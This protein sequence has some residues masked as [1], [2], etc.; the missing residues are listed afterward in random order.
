[1]K[2]H[3]ANVNVTVT[4]TIT[5]TNGTTNVGIEIPKQP[6]YEDGLIE[7]AQQADGEWEAA[8]EQV[9]PDDVPLNPEAVAEFIRE[10]LNR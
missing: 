3:T 4:P 9:I 7:G 1:M 6:S 2:V 10:L 5:I 8:L